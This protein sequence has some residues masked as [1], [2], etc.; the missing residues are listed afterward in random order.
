MSKGVKITLSVLGVIIILLIVGAVTIIGRMP[1]LTDMVYTQKD[2]GVTPDTS[3]LEPFYE[4]IGFEDRLEE[5]RSAGSNPTY[6]GEI[7]VDVTMNN[8]QV[9]AWISTY[10]NEWADMPFES[11]QFVANEDGSMEGSAMLSLEKAVGFAK[12]LGYSDEEIE[13][14][15]STVSWFD[16]SMPVYVKAEGS[17]INDQ[18]SLDVSDAQIAFYSPPQSILDGAEKVL[19][20]IYP[21][22]RSIAPAL[23]IESLT[24]EGGEMKFVGTIP[25][26]VEYK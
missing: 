17:I 11:P 12:Y 16:G 5:T 15:K 7:D 10:S 14:A 22:V 3:L 20:S 13:K 25:Q 4:E 19:E 26:S 21:K 18:I 1:L 8:D 24:N 2:L 6:S 9:N 23:S